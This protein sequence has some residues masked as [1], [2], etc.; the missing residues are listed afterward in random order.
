MTPNVLLADAVR[1][2]K[3]LLT[4]YL[5]GFNDFN[6]TTQAH[7]L[8]N[9]VAWTLGH[10]ALTM[11]RVVE[12]LTGEAIPSTDFIVG[13]S[14][15]DAHRFGTESV[16]F[17][18]QPHASPS[19]YPTLARSVAIYESACDRL[20]TCILEVPTAKLSEQISWGTGQTSIGGLVTRMVFHNGMHCGQIADLRRAL[21][22]S[23]IFA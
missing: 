12:K 17:N 7:L 18:S 20:A 4:R 14:A 8:P 23:S 16:A 2:C 1:N 9:H 22:M 13:S 11:H 15:G 21:E 10:C 5:I 6:H 3:P 19:G